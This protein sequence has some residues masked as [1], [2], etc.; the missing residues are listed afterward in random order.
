MPSVLDK[1]DI[2]IIPE[3]WRQINDTL[4]CNMIP[5]PCAL[6]SIIQPYGNKNMN[7]KDL[8]REVCRF[9]VGEEPLPT[10][11]EF[12]R[13]IRFYNEAGDISP[14]GGVAFYVR[15]NFAEDATVTF[16]FS[17]CHQKDQFNKATA[18][19]LAKNRYMEG[20]IYSVSNYNHALSLEE[21]LY[22]AVKSHLLGENLPLS[23]EI[24]NTRL[25]PVL[26]TSI[27]SRMVKMVE[28]AWLSKVES[29][30]LDFAISA[31]DFLKA[32]VYSEEKDKHSS[33]CNSCSGCESH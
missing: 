6:P 21:N 20:E 32:Y 12:Y 23:L 25:T 16:A 17:I 1:S 27:L 22:I 10:M 11:H 30:G 14:F 24:T 3:S 8:I 29:M 33:G 18:R 28:K 19:E 5:M 26:L 7:Y 13:Y 9:F 2:L 31:K 4:P 15:G